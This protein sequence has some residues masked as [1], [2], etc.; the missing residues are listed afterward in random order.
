MSEGMIRIYLVL[1]ILISV[2]CK[3]EKDVRG[4]GTPSDFLS[5]A[6]YTRM[7]IE[8]VYAKGMRPSENTISNLVEF[9]NRH[10][11]KPGGI[12]INE[13]EIPS[14]GKNPYTIADLMEVEKTHR[15]ENKNDKTI[16]A[17]LYFADADYSGNQ[18]NSKV[19]G[20][21]Y[22]ESSMAVFEKTVREISGGLTQPDRTLVEST[23][24]HHE[25]GHILGLVNNGLPPVSN[26]QDAAH[27]S[28]CKNTTCLMYY[29][30]ETSDL[31][32]NL[33]GNTV[34][35]L[36]QD[37]ADDLRAGGGK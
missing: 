36:D 32:A 11:K 18:Q 20:V 35:V 19:L 23:V 6:N 24:S 25:F 10:L 33:L 5:D 9:L 1:L 7:T 2:G 15:S 31:I 21:A 13:K 37:C 30:A 28:H 29:A 14:P 34:P 8:L 12:E 3:K 4:K 26:H 16:T 17:W 27:G 22:D